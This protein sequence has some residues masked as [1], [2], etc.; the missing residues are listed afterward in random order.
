MK[1][2]RALGSGA[3]VAGALCVV[4]ALAGCGDDGGG[5]DNAGGAGSGDMTAAPTGGGGTTGGGTT[6][7]GTT[8]TGTTGTDPDAGA[9]F[10]PA[11]LI[12]MFQ[13]TCDS[14]ITAETSCG[15]TTCPAAGMF[16]SFTCTVSCC[17]DDQ[18]GT[19]SAVEGMVT[20]CALP[21]PP[22][23]E[24]PSCPA[25]VGMAMGGNPLELPGCC[26]PEGVCGVIS[27]I[28]NTCITQ[29]MFLSD[30]QPG[31]PCDGSDADADAGM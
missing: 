18:C 17:I 25:Y 23:V 5:D 2:T 7:T 6:G 3:S 11:D 26:T 22:A 20:E 1:W 9:A 4:M 12:G 31:G 29:S 30:L 19:R 15:G 16:A 13:P 14:T 10:D 8:G 24:D 28:S 27:S 21:P